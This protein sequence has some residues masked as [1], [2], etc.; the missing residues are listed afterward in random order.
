M[1]RCERSFRPAVERLEGRDTPSH[2]SMF[3]AA[4]APPPR[5]AMMA[6]AALAPP[7]NISVTDDG[8]WNYTV[9]GTV[10]DPNPGSLTVKIVVDGIAKG[11]AT[12]TAKSTW[13]LTFGLPACTS[14]NDS[15]RYGTATA[16]DG[17]RASTA[18]VFT[19]EQTPVPPT[20]IK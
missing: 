12:V 3:R 15:T 17:T 9:S 7:T 4:H 11:S 16:T 20:P 10:T 18:A 13:T 14:A 6:P 2:V 19:I 8:E 5:E 1:G